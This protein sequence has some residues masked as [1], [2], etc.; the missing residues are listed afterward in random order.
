MQSRFA[1][2]ED[3]TIPEGDNPEPLTELLT[4]CS[5]YVGLWAQGLITFYSAD[6]CFRYLIESVEQDTSLYV[7]NTNLKIYQKGL[8]STH[9]SERR[10]RRIVAICTYY[11]QSGI[12]HA[13]WK[14]SALPF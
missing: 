1:I 14:V 5:W 6:C 10:F 2:I 13:E 3:K 7:V 8:F 9:I 12:D 11:D 4:N